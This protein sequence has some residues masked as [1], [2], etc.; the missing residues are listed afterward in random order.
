MN[1]IVRVDERAH[2]N[3]SD[4]VS[5]EGNIEEAILKLLVQKFAEFRA[6]H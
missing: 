5:C 4:E 2:H 6:F 3:V 1:A